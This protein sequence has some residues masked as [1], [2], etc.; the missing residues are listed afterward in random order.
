M[1]INQS[2]ATHVINNNIVGDNGGNDPLHIDIQGTGGLTFG[3]T[4]NNNVNWINVEG[5]TTSATT[6]TFNGAISGSGG[7]YKA[8]PNITAVLSVANT[9][10]GATTVG[11]G[12]LVMGDA[13]ADT[14]ATSGVTVASGATL[15]GEGTI[16]G[17]TTVSG[18]HAPGNGTAGDVGS[19]A[20]SSSLNYNSGSI[21]EWDIA[22]ATNSHDTVSVTGTLAVTSGAIFKVVSSTVFSDTF[23]NTNRSW[24]DIFGRKDM[25]NFLVSNFQYVAAGSQLV[26]PPSSEGYFTVSGTTLNW[27]PVPELSNLLIGGLLGAGLLLRRRATEGADGAQC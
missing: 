10:T 3:G 4:I 1:I 2:S 18:T 11:A 24:T 13:S 17:G 12:K 6:V 22:T 15:A 19:Q 7:F 27:T 14:F 16:G 8:N 26:S 21:F 5:S 23:W 25:T 9:Y 20:F